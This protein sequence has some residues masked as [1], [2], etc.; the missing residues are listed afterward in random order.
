MTSIKL[1]R[2]TYQSMQKA[3]ADQSSRVY[4]DMLIEEAA[5][6]KER[7]TANIKKAIEKLANRRKALK[8]NTGI[9][10]TIINNIKLMN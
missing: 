4:Q 7:E 5:K 6:R 10:D 2:Q 8:T 9:V 3:L 1:F